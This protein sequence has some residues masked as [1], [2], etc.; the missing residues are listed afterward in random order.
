MANYELNWNNPKPRTKLEKA[1][2][3]RDPV[4]IFSGAWL[5]NCKK[6]NDQIRSIHLN[7]ET[8][9]FLGALFIVFLKANGWAVKAGETFSSDS[10]AASIRRHVSRLTSLA[11]VMHA[12]RYQKMPASSGYKSQRRNRTS[13]EGKKR[14]K[15][16]KQMWERVK[17]CLRYKEG[18]EQKN[19]K[20]D[21]E[22]TGGRL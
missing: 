18:E 1:L 6:F 12:S 4:I 11:T 22:N 13:K 16:G 15:Q 7:F 10:G 17:N 3:S 9:P 21:G 5:Q 20:E 19:R 14:K 8:A 2:K